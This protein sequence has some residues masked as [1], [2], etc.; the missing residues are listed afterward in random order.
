MIEASA[1]G[2]LVISGEYAVLDG[3]PG[4]AVAMDIRASARVRAADRGQLIVA[5][6]GAWAFDIDS[7]GCLHWPVVPPAGQ[8]RVLAA[9]WATLA[10]AGAAPAEPRAVTLDTRAFSRQVAGAA[11]AVKLGLGSSAAV[12]AALTGALLAQTG[13]VSPGRV[14]ELATAAHRDF[15][16]GGS[17][18]DVAAAVLGGVVAL[19][20]DGGASRVRCPGWPAGLHVLAAW[21]GT[22]ASTP[23][24]LARVAAF[25]E[26]EPRACAR[27]LVPLDVAARAVLVAWEAADVPAVLASVE[28]FASHLRAFDVAG[29][30][31]IWTPAHE[32]LAGMARMAGAFYKTS[33][34]GGGDFGLALAA[35]PGPI[36]QFAAACAAEGVLTVPVDA[37]ADGVEVS[38]R[39]S[40]RG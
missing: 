1:P 33:G 37:E 23:G 9:V 11:A 27:A 18:I 35:S 22:A 25:R 32:R 21:T 14:L 7:T 20:P 30:I 17:G 4:I 31:G 12:V 5:G 19:V 16:G 28:D 13:A 15:Q 36:A 10:A 6:D 38:A 8:G 24:L 3:A 34:A 2:K 39:K 40:D 29:D 26:R